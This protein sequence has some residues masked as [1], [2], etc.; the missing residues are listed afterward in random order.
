M[1]D[2]RFPPVDTL[3]PHSGD[4]VLL[5]RILTA[6]QDS[7][8]AALTVRADGLYN[9]GD[10]VPAWVGMEYMAQAI[11]AFAG[12]HAHLE[13]R[14]VQLGFLLG[15]RRFT[16][17]RREFTVGASLTVTVRKLLQDNGGMGVFECA[18]EDHQGRRCAEARLNV[19]QPQDS[20]QYLRDIHD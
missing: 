1:S 12:W 14:P 15:S 6:D 11:A 4:L 18:L 9:H 5:D 7:L 13:Q 8:S 16:Y 10:R 19:F 17:S 2:P 20:D 3:V